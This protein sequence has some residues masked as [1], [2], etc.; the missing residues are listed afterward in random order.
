[1][2]ICEKRV[3]S[4]RLD[5]FDFIPKSTKDVPVNVP[6]DFHMNYDVALISDVVYSIEVVAALVAT[7]EATG[8][9]IC[10]VSMPTARLGAREFIKSM[11]QKFS[12][13]RET[14]E[15]GILREK[16]EAEILD[17]YLYHFRRK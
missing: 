6:E 5:W 16:N 2:E 4:L 8:C 17:T 14:L 10:L 12:V 13:E 1:M 3:Y 7:I 15:K 9:T 11:K